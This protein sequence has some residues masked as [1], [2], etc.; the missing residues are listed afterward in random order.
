M[1]AEAELSGMTLFA[2]PGPEPPIALPLPFLLELG[3]QGQFGGA[4]DLGDRDI[5]MD[6]AHVGHLRQLVAHKLL[7]VVDAPGDNLLAEFAS[8]VDAVQG[9]LETQELLKAKNAE[10][11]ENR[12]M[13]FRIGIN[14]GDVI[15]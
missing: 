10:L 14:L 11:P 15:E 5:G 2:C 9:A 12:R 8:V 3:V 7:V 6:L 13:Q 4:L 1:D